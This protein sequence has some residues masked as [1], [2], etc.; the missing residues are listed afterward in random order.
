MAAYIAALLEKAAENHPHIVGQP[1]D[2]DIFAM[3]EILFPILHDADY[4]MTVVQGRVNHNLVGLIQS[5]AAY[6]A[7]WTA[8]FPRPIRPATYDPTIPEAATSVTRNR[9][10]AAH[11]ARIKDYEIFV[12]AE[13]GVSA[14]IQKAVEETWFKS[15]RDP[16]TFY[17]SVTSY[18]LLDHLRNNS[19]GLHNNDL[20]SL[21]AEMLHYY[22][23]EEGIPEFILALEKAREK[24]SRGGLPM[25]D[26]QV[27]A[28][29]HAQVFASLHYPEATREWERLPTASKTWAA[30]QTKYRQANVERLRLLRAQANAFGGAA[31]G[32]ATMVITNVT[33]S[34]ANDT[35]LADA[36]TQIANA[37]TNDN[38][39]LAS[40]VAQLTALTTRMDSMQHSGPTPATTTRGATPTGPTP[41][42]TTTTPHPPRAPRQ[43]RGR[44]FTQA[45]ALQ[46]F[47][48]TGY[49]STH[50]WRVK[51]S[52]TSKTCTRRNQWHKE[53]ATRADTMGGCNR[54]KGWETNP[55]PM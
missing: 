20:A 22:A 44:T 29:A 55:N 2:D 34:T 1:T 26:A 28:T 50:G 19:G 36:L 38:S 54:N 9:M 4:D 23:N 41:P 25:S 3:T 18:D 11:S 40:M 53:D 31:T 47:D 16:I 51:A 17:N 42:A 49:C 43:P 35:A 37:S 14:F 48:P 21:P 30:W 10:E 6:A 27:L 52:H 5:S 12:A 15:L 33:N 39:L 45:E 13:K 24:L 8:V 32:A 7:T 46:I